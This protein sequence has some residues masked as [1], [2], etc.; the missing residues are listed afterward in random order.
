MSNWTYVTG[1]IVGNTSLASTVATT[2]NGVTAGNLICVAV[3]GYYHNTTY[4][5]A[6]SAGNYYVPA[7]YQAFTAEN[8]V[9]MQTYYCVPV[10]G[11]N[12]T[13]TGTLASGG[14]GGQDW[15]SIV[16][17][18]YSIPALNYP[19]YVTGGGNNVNDTSTYMSNQAFSG[20]EQF[21]IWSAATVDSIATN[22]GTNV[23]ITMAAGTNYTQ[24]GVIV[25]TGG[26]QNALQSED[27]GVTAPLLQA[28]SPATVNANF[29]GLSGSGISAICAIVFGIK[30]TAMGGI[31]IGM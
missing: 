20:P 16:A 10:T 3:C 31:L 26:V 17:D 15:M 28:N 5:L 6:D 23:P 11:G 2:I 30:P 14:S 29:T 21:L 7:F 13:L 12:L 9:N 19:G 24:R 18:V 4:T 8:S 27:R 22:D 1:S 25:N